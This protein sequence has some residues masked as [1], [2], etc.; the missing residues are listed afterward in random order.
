MAATRAVQVGVGVVLALG[1]VAG[2][3]YLFRDAPPAPV[4]TGQPAGYDS[5]GARIRRVPLPPPLEAVSMAVLPSLQP[6]MSRAEVED[7]IGPPSAA[8][9][10]PI[11][12]AGGR[13]TY[14]TAY[15]I[16]LAACGGGGAA[17]PPAGAGPQCFVAFEFDATLPGHPLVNVYYPDPLF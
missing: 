17:R 3:S 1:A 14:R 10:E 6:G 11:E 7:V 12:A 2:G 4:V 16:E 8:Q 5:N 13:T 9:V 15:P